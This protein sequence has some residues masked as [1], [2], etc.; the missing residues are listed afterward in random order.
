MTVETDDLILRLARE[1]KP[2]SA[3]ALETRLFGCVAAG[4]A[5]AFAALY[6]TLGVRA[7]LAT[8]LTSFPFWMKAGYTASIAAIAIVV[9]AHLARP[10]SRPGRWY[11]LL[12]APTL[13]LAIAAATQVA[14]SPTA[15]WP[16]LFFGMSAS[17]CSVRILGFA[18]PVF[19]GLMWAFRSFAPTRLRA[20][21]AAAGLAS[22]AVGAAIYVLYCREVSASFVLSW[23]TLGILLPAIAGA[24]LGPR[25]LRW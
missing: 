6:L 18:T 25:L 24:L 14:T 9:A 17:K 21:G 1:V 22:G 16:D 5:V 11:A 13:L 12:I 23:Y 10:D 19:V 20:A 8:A 7:D 3:R 4:A 2:V 15:Q